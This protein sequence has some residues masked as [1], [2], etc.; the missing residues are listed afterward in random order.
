MKTIL[1]MVIS[2]VFAVPAAFSQSENELPIDTYG[3]EVVNNDSRTL[4]YRCQWGYWVTLSPDNSDSRSCTA[5]TVEFFTL[6][7]PW[8]TVQ[9]DCVGGTRKVTITDS[10]DAY[11]TTP[12]NAEVSDD[13]PWS[14][15]LTSECV[16]ETPSE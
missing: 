3:F 12:G 1:V 2:F 8:P 15:T 9:H 11:I 13:G 5:T 7:A 14:L 4:R 10:E 6:N 16:T